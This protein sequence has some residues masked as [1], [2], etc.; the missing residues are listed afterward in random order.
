MCEAQETKTKLSQFATDLGNVHTLFETSEEDTC[1]Q[2]IQ[3]HTA[4]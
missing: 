3:T 4:L 2:R 1:R